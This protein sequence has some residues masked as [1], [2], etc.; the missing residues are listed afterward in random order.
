V[1]GLRDSF[2]VLMACVWYGSFNLWWGELRLIPRSTFYASELYH[3]LNGTDGLTVGP[4][5]G[6]VEAV[7]LI[8][9]TWVIFAILLG[10]YLFT[11]APLVLIFES[12]TFAL[13]LVGVIIGNL[14]L[15]LLSASLTLA[16]GIATLILPG[17]AF[18]KFISV[19]EMSL[20]GMILTIKMEQNLTS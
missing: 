16:F 19:I 12:L 2:V 1:N 4:L 5:L 13:T 14:I 7:S 8:F 17:G 18:E 9:A 11:N 6:N 10:P 15:T 20:A 3:R